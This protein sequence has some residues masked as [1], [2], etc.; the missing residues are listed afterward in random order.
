MTDEELSNFIS[1]LRNES[2]LVSVINEIKDM[3]NP[4]T[5]DADFATRKY[6]GVNLDTPVTNLYHI[7]NQNSGRWRKGSSG[8][9]ALS[10]EELMVKRKTYETGAT[11]A[12]EYG[13][14]ATMNRTRREDRYSNMKRREAKEISDEDLKRIVNRLNMEQQY[15]NLTTKDVDVG[16][17]RLEDVLSTVGS[18]MTIAAAGAGLALTI[19][20]LMP[21]S[22]KKAVTGG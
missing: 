11:I 9:T 19:K 3:N 21:D 13:N 4:M 20:Q 5:S 7:G 10:K 6:E 1:R 16:K 18:M 12:K 2:E 22:A 8:N 14:L 17:S 15:R